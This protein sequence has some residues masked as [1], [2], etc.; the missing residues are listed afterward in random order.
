[1]DTYI[2]GWEK[3]HIGCGG[4]VRFVENLCQTSVEQSACHAEWLFECTNCGAILYEEQ[5]EFERMG[6]DQ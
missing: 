4:L 6:A 1:M 5:V 2:R 3:R